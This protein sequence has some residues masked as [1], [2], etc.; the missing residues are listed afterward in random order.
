MSLEA[1]GLDL[2]QRQLEEQLQQAN[3][4]IAALQVENSQL[5]AANPASDALRRNEELLSLASQAIEGFFYDWNPQTG[6]VHRF[7]NP[8]NVIGIL[9]NETE[10]T[11]DWWQDRVHPEDKAFSSL[12]KLNALPAHQNHFETEF[13]FRH[14]LGHWIHLSDRAYIVRDANGIPQRVVGSTH[15][16]TECKQLELDLNEQRKRLRF[17]AQILETTSDAVIALDPDLN[18]RYCNAS[19]ERM[20]GVPLADAIGKP[21]P[22]MHGYA[23]LAPED[24]ARSLADLRDRG[25]WTGEYVHIL[26]DKSQRVV[27][28]TVNTLAPEA[29]GGMVSVIRDVT[30]RKR[31]EIRAQTHASQL[32]R[33][34]EDLL[35][36]AYAV[37]HDLQAPVRTVTA[38]SQLLELQN[39]E[40]LDEAGGQLL[41]YIRDAGLRMNTLISDLLEFAKVAGSEVE[42]RHDVSLEQ[43]LG[44]A[45][46]NLRSVMKETGAVVTHDPLPTVVADQGQLVHLFQNLI[47]NPIKYRKPDTPP[48]VHISAKRNGIDD[49]WIVSIQD[50]GI[51]FDPQHA[52]RIFRAFE[53]LHGREFAGTGIGLTICRR[54]VDRRGG[55]IWADARPGQGATFSF[56]IPDS[57]ETI[58]AAPAMDWDRV[59]SVLTERPLPFDEMFQAFE[60]AQC[61]VH[62]LDGSITAWTKGA[63]R[64]FGWT[65]AE[66]TGTRIHDLLQ[67]KFPKPLHEIEA[68]LLRADEWTGQVTVT[69]RSGEA[70]WSSTRWTLFRDRDGRP[71]FITEIHTDISGL[72]G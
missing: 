28:C 67:T 21:L 11:E 71:Q 68:D 5:R 63:E 1:A 64:L 16:V 44:I 51:G 6:V 32:A 19:A 2:R 33:A 70:I 26:R 49:E 3:A 37:S 36:F 31:T 50:N 56:T 57:T 24:E 9:A 52:E 60:L 47:G 66:A 62:S 41:H 61:V 17:Q 45:L 69:K 27:H 53:R 46:E 54:I 35:L 25:I 7:G 10:P 72:K 39:K 4:R 13:R 43:T 42:F 29:G 58:Q 65:K 18:V 12:S 38:F 55:R 23:W 20:Y 22:F 59:H 30:E 15:D 40:Q 48:H 34:N 14:Q 8:E